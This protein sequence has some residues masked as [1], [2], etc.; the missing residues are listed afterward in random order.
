MIDEYTLSVLLF[1]SFLAVIIYKDRKNI[2]IKYILFMR[3]TRKFKRFIDKTA[4]LFPNFWKILG[5]FGVLVC[6]FYMIQGT[7]LLTVFQPQVQLVLPSLSSEVT[8]S[9][10]SINIP[11]WTWFLVILFIMVPHEFFHGVMARTEKI[12]LKSVGL[13]L[14]AVFPGAFVEPDEKQV[15]KS[16][17]WPKLRI[18]AAGSFANFIVSFV[19]FYLTL[20][21]IWPFFALP[22]ITLVEVEPYSPAELAGLKQGMFITE[23]ND[24]KVIPTY[25][26]YLGGRSYL[27]EEIGIIDNDTSIKI[28]TWDGQTFQVPILFNETSN[29]SYMGIGYRINFREGN[30]VLMLTIIQIISMISFF[31]LAV[32]I[33]NILPIYPLDGGLM[34]EAVTDKYFKKQSKKIVKIITIFVLI[35]LVYSFVKPFL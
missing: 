13:L 18:F 22:G 31:S 16:K 12:R 14:L 6:F 30:E 5:T 15:K 2:D 26:E 20:Y 17:I 29:T 8:V 34:V 1:F 4:K 27:S 21:T 23:I 3:R 24:T 28:K 11:F 9:D 25:Q 32:G 19:L 10:V 33:V 35:I 7:Y